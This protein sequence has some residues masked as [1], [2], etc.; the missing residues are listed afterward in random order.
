MVIP[1]SLSFP[2][3]FI[4]VGVSKTIN[5][6]VVRGLE[7]EIPTHCLAFFNKYWLDTA[8]KARAI[9]IP[10]ITLNNALEFEWFVIALVR[11]SLMV[12]FMKEG[13]YIFN[14]DGWI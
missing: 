12:E 14:V 13:K 7:W 4:Y 6:R 3:F 9:S 10:R 8:K 5:K 11:I 2:F 1:F